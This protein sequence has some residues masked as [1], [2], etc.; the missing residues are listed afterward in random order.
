MPDRDEETG[1]FSA[2]VDLADVEEFFTGGEPR[3]TREVA[4]RFDL[5]RSRAYELLR[6]LEERG[7]ITSKKL[8]ELGGVV[9]W[10]D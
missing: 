8:E 10:R 7:S 6:E 1:R 3:S 9:W 2:A 4:D 5:S